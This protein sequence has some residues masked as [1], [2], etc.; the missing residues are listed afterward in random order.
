[1]P[2]TMGSMWTPD[3]V[4]ETPCTTCRNVGRY[5]IDP[6]IAKPTM[7]PMTEVSV[8]LRLR[9]RRSGRTGSA[10]RLSTARNAPSSTT[11]STPHPT[12]CQE[13]QG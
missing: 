9:N 12:I 13:P 6:N 4:G 11:P 1:M 3:R 8:K 7:K 5:V 10:A 2:A